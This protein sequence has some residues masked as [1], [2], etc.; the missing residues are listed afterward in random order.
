[1][2]S[3]GLQQLSQKHLCCGMALEDSWVMVDGQR[4]DAI[5][6]AGI[7]RNTQSEEPIPTSVFHNL[8]LSPREFDP[9]QL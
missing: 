2:V 5:D 6:K 4:P 7:F 1:M 3:F 8:G 9:R